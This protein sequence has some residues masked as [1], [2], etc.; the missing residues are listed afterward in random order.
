MRAGQLDQRVTI[1][2]FTSEPDDWGQPIPSWAP[3]A[4]VWAAVEPLVGREYITAQAMQS[5]VTARIRMRWRPG[6]T[7]QDRVMHGA[8]AYGIESVIDYRSQHR[9]L[10]LICKAMG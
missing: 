3:L 7:S 2:R 6:V 8:T 4:T 5:E 10:V 9:E 1:E